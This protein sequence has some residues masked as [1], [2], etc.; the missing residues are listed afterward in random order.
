MSLRL[1]IAKW[2]AP[3]LV[4]K[5][6]N[7]QRSV[8]WWQ[9]LCGRRTEALIER[10]VALGNIAALRTPNCASIGKRMADI[11]EEALR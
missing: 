2:L 4:E 5:V 3:E 1:R 6:E 7:L 9:D 8:Y 10:N 11:A